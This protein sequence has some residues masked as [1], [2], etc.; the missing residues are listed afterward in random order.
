MTTPYAYDYDLDEQWE[1]GFL[2]G[3]IADNDPISSPS[4]ELHLDDIGVSWAIDPANQ[5]YIQEMFVEAMSSSDLSHDALA[6]FV[7]PTSTSTDLLDSC[8]IGTMDDTDFGADTDAFSNNFD[9]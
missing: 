1:Q 6:N 9:M 5:E 7:S 2:T 4:L 3:K 8:N